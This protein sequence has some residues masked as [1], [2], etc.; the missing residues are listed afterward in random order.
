MPW[1][2]NYDEIQV[3]EN[4]MNAFWASGYEA[5]SMSDLVA[6]T[7][8]NRGSIYAAFDDKHHLFIRALK[9]YDQTHR[10]EH[11]QQLCEQHAP[12]ES[13]IAAFESAAKIPENNTQPRGCLLVNTALELSPHDPEVRRFVNQSLQAVEKFFRDRL[14]AA[15]HDNTIDKSLDPVSTAQTLLGLFLGLRVLTRSQA[16]NASA[17]SIVAQVKSMLN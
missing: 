4:A 7:G 12:K 10:I 6:A 16:P 3:L 8:I 5:T 17:D 13:I 9:H 1:Q 14:V 11:L 2:K 15:Q